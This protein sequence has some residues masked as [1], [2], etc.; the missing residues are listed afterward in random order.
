MAARVAAAAKTG[1]SAGR[2]H[3]WARR[4][5]GDPRGRGRDRDAARDRSCSQT[6]RGCAPSR[7]PAPGPTGRR[8]CARTS[9]MRDSV[10]RAVEEG[11]TVYLL[12]GLPYDR[13]VWREQW[14]PI[15]R[16]VVA[17]CASKGARL[18]FFDNVYMYGKVEGPMTEATP[19]RPASAKGAVRA[20]IAGF[21]QGEMAA[22]RVTAH[23]RARGRLLRPVRRA[24]RHALDPRAAAAR[25]RQGGAGAGPG[26][27]EALLHLHAR[28]RAGAAP[29]RRGGRRV[30]SGLAPPDGASAAHRAGVR[31]S[32]RARARRPGPAHGHAALDGARGGGVQHAAARGGRDALPE[33]ARLRVPLREVRERGSRSPRR[34][35]RRVSARRWRG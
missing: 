14:P 31:R 9:P 2:R 27:R 12:A 29:A 16:N 6:A 17:A 3:G 24:Q 22:G 20:E 7:A 11:S 26:R 32:R 4:T 35:T 15:M 1:G 33:R 5:A 34:R 10:L 13:N 19:V 18:V 8:R 28:L 30:R 21:L 25:R 23:D